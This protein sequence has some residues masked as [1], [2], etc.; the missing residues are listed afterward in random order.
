MTISK[1]DKGADFDR[2]FQRVTQL[3]I[4]TLNGA[5]FEVKDQPGFT[6]SM[7]VK[8]EA[9]AA[10]HGET[11]DHDGIWYLEILRRVGYIDHLAAMAE[12]DA[13]R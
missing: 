4:Y 8:Q 12:A 6:T 13:A 7:R 3:A 10:A 2:R 1:D 9:V 11:L 5:G